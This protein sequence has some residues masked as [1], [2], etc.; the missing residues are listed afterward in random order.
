[1]PQATTRLGSVRTTAADPARP[2]GGA[3]ARPGP[4]PQ[5]DP[6]HRAAASHARCSGAAILL[7]G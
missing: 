1:M 6:A 4:A 3:E 2:G 7:I 5:S